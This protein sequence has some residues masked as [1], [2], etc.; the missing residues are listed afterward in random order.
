VPAGRVDEGEGPAQAA[1]RELL[2]E[3]GYRAG[4]V[5]ELGAFYPTNGISP[6]HARLFAALDCTRVQAPTPG[7]CEQFSVH[8]VPADEVRRRLYRGE[9]ADGFTAL[10]LFYWFA[11]EG[12]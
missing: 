7:P 2:E 10:A 5:I 12:R 8:V 4:K 9:Y 11:R 6:H 3:T 1:E